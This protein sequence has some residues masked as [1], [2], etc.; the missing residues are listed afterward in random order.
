MINLIYTPQRADFKVE[1]IVKDDLLTVK[2]DTATEIFD[3]AELEEGIAEEIIAEELPINP[4]MSIEKTGDEINIT[5]IR[6][7]SAEEKELFENGYN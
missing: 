7:Y 4:I 6:F 5:V 2:I 3:F 1:Y